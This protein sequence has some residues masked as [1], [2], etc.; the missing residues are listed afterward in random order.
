MGDEPYFIDQ[1]SNKLAQN[2]LSE[3]EKAFGQIVL[4]GKDSDAGAVI[5]LCRQMPM[6]GG[7]QVVIV[8]EAQQMRKLDQ[9]SLYTASPLQSTILILCHKEKSMDKRWQLYKHC[10][11]KG[12]VLESV[13][14]RDYEFSGWLSEFVRSKGCNMDSKAASMLT[15]HIGADISKISG[16]LDKL[17]TALPE[18]TKTITAEIIEQNIGISKDFN[19][20]E[21]TRALSERNLYKCLLIAD[22]FA[23]NPKDNP[24]LLTIS[25]MFTHFQR[26]FLVNYYRWLATRARKPSPMPNDMEMARILKLPSPFFLR[27][28]QAAASLYPNN[29]VFA[30]IGLLRE[31]DMKSKGI[32]GG[33][34]DDGELLKELLLRILTL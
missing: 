12:A 34:A 19:T 14:P 27:E 23:R 28:Y 26:I 32:N 7:Y 16:E 9:L 33:S 5:N 1:L 21:L 3:A 13:R 11:E 25:S 4:Y 15:D 10:A 29:K 6:M 24:L 8:R 18:G 31:Y 22:H 30:I 20:F 17:L 2:I